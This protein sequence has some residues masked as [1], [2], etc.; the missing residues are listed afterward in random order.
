MW[1]N[2]IIGAS[3]FFIQ[4]ETFWE[5]NNTDYFVVLLEKTVAR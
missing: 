4:L 3:P 5:K 2:E 1:K